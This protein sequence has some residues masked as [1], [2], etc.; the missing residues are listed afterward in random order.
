M[1]N[2]RKK[3]IIKK[4]KQILII[5]AIFIFLFIVQAKDSNKNYFLILIMQI[6]GILKLI[7][8]IYNL[9]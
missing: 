9:S 7:K 4:D 5:L 2:K 3:N 1:H 8:N 6:L